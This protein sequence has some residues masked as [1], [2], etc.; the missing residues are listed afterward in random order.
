MR[1]PAV[2]PRARLIMP[3][4]AVTLTGGPPTDPTNRPAAGTRMKLQP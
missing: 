2:A 1:N 3:V 4:V